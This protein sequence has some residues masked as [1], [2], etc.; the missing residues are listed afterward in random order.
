MG[1]S[2]YYSKPPDMWRFRTMAEHFGPLSDNAVSTTIGQ[3][4]VLRCYAATI[5]NVKRLCLL[6]GLA[7]LITAAFALW[8]ISYSGA[9]WHSATVVTVANSGWARYFETVDSRD[10]DCRLLYRERNPFR[11]LSLTPGAEIQVAHAPYAGIFVRDQRGRL[12]KGAMVRQALMARPS[13]NGPP[14]GFVR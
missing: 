13:R 1:L 3:C 11:P 10:P 2:Q 5:A 9:R 6:F 7:A 8:P 14:A 12:H 4:A